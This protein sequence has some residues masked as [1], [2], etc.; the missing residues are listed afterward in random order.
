MYSFFTVFEIAPEICAQKKGKSVIPFL[1]VNLCDSLKKTKKKEQSVSTFDWDRYLPLSYLWHLY[2]IYEPYACV[3]TVNLIL[4]IYN[5]YIRINSKY[6][7]NMYSLVMLQF[8]MYYFDRLGIRLF[9]LFFVF[10]L[11]INIHLF[12][13]H[14]H[15]SMTMTI[16][17]TIGMR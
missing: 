8:E 12:F 13:L 3:L 14:S 10:F 11:S 17:M 1:F 9:L 16:H 2:K 7:S 4:S 15:M 6:Y 5:I